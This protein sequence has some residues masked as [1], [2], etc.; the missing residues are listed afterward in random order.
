MTSEIVQP[1]DGGWGWMCC[2][3]GFMVNVLAI[4]QL[5]SYGILFIEFTERY[6]S[7]A[8]LTEWV[9]GLAFG[10]TFG[11]G[12]ISLNSQQQKIMNK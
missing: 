12:K 6:G 3:A 10:L 9:N 11:F 7:S 5:K 1:P 8:A 4:G 2:L